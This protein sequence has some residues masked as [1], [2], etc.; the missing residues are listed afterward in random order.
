MRFSS[1][2]LLLVASLALLSL[3]SVA[4]QGGDPINLEGHYVYHDRDGSPIPIPATL[5]CTGN[6]D[7]ATPSYQATLELVP[8]V[9]LGN[10][11]INSR[12]VGFGSGPSP[13]IIGGCQDDQFTVILESDDG[14]SG[15]IFAAYQPCNSY[16]GGSSIYKKQPFESVGPSHGAGLRHKLRKLLAGPTI[17]DTIPGN[18]TGKYLMIDR[19]GVLP[20]Q[21]VLIWCV[22]NCSGGAS[23]P[24]PI[25]RG[26]FSTQSEFVV[27]FVPDGNVG[28]GDFTV[29]YPDGSICGRVPFT[30]IVPIAGMAG[31]S[32]LLG[33]AAPMPECLFTG[34]A[35]R[36]NSA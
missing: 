28:F 11:V 7:S 23:D 15:N 9:V 3:S 14:S 10:L 33:A 26:T 16:V 34:A 20:T 35:F 19:N 36:F 4:A 2:L 21:N 29:A 8:G 31:G 1:A 5:T 6:C 17:V 18:S 24:P 22:E 32:P 13:K 25:Y 27:S 12:L 30:V